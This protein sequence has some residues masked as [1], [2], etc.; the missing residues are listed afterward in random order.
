MKQNELSV[1]VCQ[2]TS[3]NSLSKN[4]DQIKAL[5]ES[6]PQPETIDIISLPENCFFMRMSEGEEVQYLSIEDPVFDYYKVFAKKNDLLIHIGATPI[7]IDHKFFNGT[8]LIMPDGTVQSP[9]QK[10][11][12][13]DIQLENKKPVRES[14]AFEKGARPALLNYRGWNLGFTICYDLRFSEL[15]LYYQ[16]NKADCV[17]IPSAFLVETGK[18]HWEVLNRAR[19]IEGQYYVVSSAQGGKHSET[20]FTYGHSMAVDPWGKVVA[21]IQDESKPS[22]VQTI[23]KSQTIE[24][25]RKQIPMA[26]HRRMKVEFSD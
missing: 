19:A 16:L 2:L 6:I 24:E 26:S 5:L 4:H 17:F 22:W 18:L 7:K 12:L 21:E 11:H 3:T 14:D 10:I 25:I 13:F 1:V 15:Y 9:Y 23:L 8:V 20:R